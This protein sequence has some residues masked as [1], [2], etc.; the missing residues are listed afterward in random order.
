MNNVKYVIPVII[1]QQGCSHAFDIGG[2]RASKMILGPFCLKY[3]GA[4][5]LPGPSTLSK[6]T[7]LIYT[8]TYINIYTYWFAAH[9]IDYEVIL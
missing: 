7:P 5:T 3:W 9:K 6:T 2:P 1:Q 8:K 4:Q